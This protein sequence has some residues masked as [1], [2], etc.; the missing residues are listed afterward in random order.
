MNFLAHIHLAEPTP[1][2]RMGNLLGDF[3]KGLPWDARF[4]PDIW[5]GIM[6]HRY[7]DAFTDRH[8]VWRMSRD[9]L[10]REYRR[11]AGIVIDIYYDYFLSRH[12][13]LFSPANSLDHFIE[14]IHDDLRSTLDLVPEEAET[15]ILRM[16]DE[17][18]LESYAALDGVKMTLLRVS[19]RS[20]ALSLVGSVHEKMRGCID[21]MEGHFLDYYPD[22]VRYLT[23]LRPSLRDQ[24]GVGKKIRNPDRYT[25]PDR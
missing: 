3:V 24:S 1:A 11:Y 15:V 22:L 19:R 4:P 10:P 18:W 5:H 8:P 6:E 21:E 2:S 13:G 23:V 14:G 9:L 20:A 7:V 12:W 16:M 17:R 25:F